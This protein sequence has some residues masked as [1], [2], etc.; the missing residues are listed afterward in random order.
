M[1]A[2][3]FDASMTLD[4]VRLVTTGVESPTRD[5]SCHMLYFSYVNS[6]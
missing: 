2:H 6:D 1:S 3:S 5:V 4:D